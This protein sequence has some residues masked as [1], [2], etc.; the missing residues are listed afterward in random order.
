MLMFG[1]LCQVMPIEFVRDH[2]WSRLH[3]ILV[4]SMIGFLLSNPSLDYKLKSLFDNGPVM[5]AIFI[6]KVYHL[7]GNFTDFI[8]GLF[9]YGIAFIFGSLQFNREHLQTTFFSFWS[10]FDSISVGTN[11]SYLNDAYNLPSLSCNL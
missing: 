7:R 2:N 4:Q 6:T 5:C 8:C 10:C 11:L 3:Y 1:M 9:Y